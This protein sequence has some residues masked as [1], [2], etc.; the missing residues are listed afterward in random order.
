MSR[1]PASAAAGP[2]WALPALLAVAGLANLDNLWDTG[3]FKT[4]LASLLAGALLLP[5]LAWSGAGRAALI[6]WLRGG[7]GRLLVLATLCAAP[8][9]LPALDQAPVTDRLL[10]FGL[11]NLAAAA[12]VLASRRSPELLLRTLLV[13]GLVHGGLCLLQALGLERRLTPGPEEVVGLSGN[14]IR[15]GALCALALVAAVARALAPVASAPGAMDTI[16]RVRAA[17]SWRTWLPLALVAFLTL[18]LLLTRARG[19]R[20]AA[21]AVLALL[22]VLAFR[23]HGP[24]VARRALA[25]ALALVAG[26]SLAA[27]AGGEGTLAAR[28]LDDQAPVVSGRDPTTEVRLALLRSGLAMVAERPWLGVGYGRYREH[29]QGHREADEAALP[30]LMGGVTEVEHPHNEFLLA[31]IEGGVPSALF[32]AALLARGLRRA[33]RLAGRCAGSAGPVALAIVACGVLLALVQDVLT[34]PATAL[35]VFAALGLCWAPARDDDT[36]DG[37][38]HDHGDP[39]TGDACPS[40]AGIAATPPRLLALPMLLLGA[41]LLLLAW[42]RLDAHMSLRSFVRRTDSEGRMTQEGF[43]L[44]VRASRAAPGDAAVQRIVLDFGQLY[45][46][47]VVNADGQAVVQHELDLARQRLARLLP[48]SPAGR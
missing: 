13:I 7:G 1:S 46:L 18:A 28:K 4:A 10:L 34:D 8:L 19:A 38:A 25:L 9:A 3:V 2:A 31:A 37:D 22:L 29:A 12:G 39:S 27:V 30:G 24:A 11:L 23:R 42:P 43:Q 44:L 41:G 47:R 48:A 26:V 6:T 36:Q 15:A 35:P 33:L 5:V 16:R 21:L 45:L 40:Q 32:F 14:S 20:W 17:E